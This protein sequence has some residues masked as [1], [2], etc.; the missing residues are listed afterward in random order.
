MT[1]RAPTAIA[2]SLVLLS[3]GSAFAEQWPT[4]DRRAVG[5]T[6][7]P[8]RTQRATVWRP[9]DTPPSLP[10]EPVQESASPSDDRSAPIA[11]DALNVDKA[12]AGDSAESGD[13]FDTPDPLDTPALDA[14]VGKA[15]FDAPAGEPSARRL[16][17]PTDD[18]RSPDVPAG[19]DQRQAFVD[20]SWLSL[21]SNTLPTTAAAATLAIGLLLLTIGL[22]KRAMPRSARPLPGD[23]VS[24]LGRVPLAGKQSAQLMKVG[25]KLV[26]VAMT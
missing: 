7:L 22:L 15:A 6:G 23:V 9:E 3:M 8:L 5:P 11:A 16:R 13:E 10:D 14:F 25:G 1:L 26:L 24:L 19:S 21:G 18:R 2:V 17:P 20:L 12:I 4:L